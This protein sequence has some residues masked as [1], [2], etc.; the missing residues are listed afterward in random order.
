MAKKEVE[1]ELRKEFQ[2]VV[3]EMIMVEL[4]NR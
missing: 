1:P 4:E 3:D 2:K